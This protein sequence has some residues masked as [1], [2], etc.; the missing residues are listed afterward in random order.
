MS[1]SSLAYTGNIVKRKV[2]DRDGKIREVYIPCPVLVLEYNKYMGGVDPTRRT[3]RWYR[4]LFLHFFNI[5]STKT[6]TMPVE[7]MELVSQLCVVEIKT[8]FSLKRQSGQL[9]VPYA[10]KSDSTVRDTLKYRWCQERSGKRMCNINPWRCHA[11]AIPL[12][13]LSE[14]Q[15]QFCVLSG[16]ASRA[17]NKYLFCPCFYIE[18]K[19]S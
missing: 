1:H 9:P 15:E 19:M 5:A 7:L 4:T 3:S 14:Q 17:Y 10:Q 2:K 13:L 6:Y 18:E 12:C 16:F 8:E 11:R